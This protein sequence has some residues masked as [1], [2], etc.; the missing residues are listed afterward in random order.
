ML[1]VSSP[2]RNVG[3]PLGLSHSEIQCGSRAHDNDRLQVRRIL[4]FCTACLGREVEGFKERTMEGGCTCRH[5][6]YRLTGKPMIVH[7]CHCRWC[8]RETG[9]VHALNA[10]YE[11]DRVVHTAGDPEIISTPSAS[12]KG[13]LIAKRLVSDRRVRRS[14]PAA[15]A[16]ASSGFAIARPRG[17]PASSQCYSGA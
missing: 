5:V 14:S 3:V 9:T 15:T 4:P 17:W 7:A 13:Q 2:P 16:P 11:A 8:Q 12:G 10:V 1:Q 6:R